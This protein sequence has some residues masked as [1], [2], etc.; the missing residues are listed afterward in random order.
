MFNLA[1]AQL[2][3]LLAAKEDQLQAAIAARV[4]AEGG[5]LVGWLAG[6]T[7]ARRVLSALNAELDKV[8]PG[9]SDLRLAFEGWVK[10]EGARLEND[11]ERAAAL[12]RAL[13]DALK[14]PAVA[15]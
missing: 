3:T 13:R 6:A 1:I 10:A 7:I 5:A 12:G 2:K 15:T 8:E 11:P 9:D 4:R 14:H